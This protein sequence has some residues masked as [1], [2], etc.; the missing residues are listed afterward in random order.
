[1]CTYTIHASTHMYY[2]S[3]W[4]HFGIFWDLFGTFLGPFC[5]IVLNMWQAYGDPY[6]DYLNHNLGDRCSI[7]IWRQSPYTSS[8]PKGHGSGT[9]TLVRDILFQQ[10]TK[11]F[12]AAHM[13][14]P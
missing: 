11:T 7:A 1:M 3:I 2:M 14:C 6:D 4:D 13:G 5:Y 8:K 9:K 10:Q 12:M